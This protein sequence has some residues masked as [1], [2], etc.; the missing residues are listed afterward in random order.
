MSR[1]ARKKFIERMI[2]CVRLLRESK[3]NKFFQFFMLL[4]NGMRCNAYINY[5][6]TKHIQFI[7]RLCLIKRYRPSFTKSSIETSID[8][9]SNGIFLYTMPI[10]RL[11][12]FFID[13]IKAVATISTGTREW[14]KTDTPTTTTTLSTLR[15]SAGIFR[16]VGI[17]A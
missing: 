15:T 11:C 6:H 10:T 8:M 2:A 14:N 17:C 1:E 16:R 9:A 5:K 7:N 4:T 12:L 13:S 3:N